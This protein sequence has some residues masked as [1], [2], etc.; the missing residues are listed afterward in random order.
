M[1]A[2]HHDAGAWAAAGSRLHRHVHHTS[3]ASLARTCEPHGLR[4]AATAPHA[5]FVVA[6]AAASGRTNHDLWPLC[7][8][9]AR[10]VP[11]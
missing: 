6:S 11:H 7:L 2:S 10:K 3:T 8:Q 5:L 4:H 9:G 1:E